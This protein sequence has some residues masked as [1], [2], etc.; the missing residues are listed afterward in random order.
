M[1]ISS[2]LARKGADVVVIDPDATLE[3][4]ARRMADREVGALVVSPDGRRPEGVVSERDLLRLVAREGAS[5]LARPVTEAM[6]REPT[7]CEPD[8]KVDE[9]AAVMTDQRVRHVPVVDGGAM[10][11]IVSIGDV[12]KSRLDELEVET[13]AL[14][15]YLSTGR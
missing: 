2:I 12:V 3:E 9:L 15:S 13:Q 1:R 10:V 7:T 5:C 14:S 6:T 4:A 11:G 8:T